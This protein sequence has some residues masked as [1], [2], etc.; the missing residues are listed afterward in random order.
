MK[1]RSPLVSFAVFPLSRSGLLA[2][3]LPHHNL[4]QPGSVLLP[5]FPAFLTE[6][7]VALAVQ[8]CE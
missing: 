6:P 2:H 1:P 4:C 7:E 8:E 5:S 3:T